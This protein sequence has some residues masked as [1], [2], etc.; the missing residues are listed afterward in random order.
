M[1]GL[2]ESYYG[3]TTNQIKAAYYTAL[4]EAEREMANA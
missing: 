2:A 1:S 3:H 4:S